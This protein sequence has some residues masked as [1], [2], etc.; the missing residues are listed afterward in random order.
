MI[1][2]YPSAILI[3]Q[4]LL[5]DSLVLST[6]VSLVFKETTYVYIIKHKLFHN[7]KI[8]IMINKNNNNKMVLNKQ[9]LKDYK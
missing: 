1:H 8:Q 7:K 2:L 4:N 6:T 5:N 9:S 3:N